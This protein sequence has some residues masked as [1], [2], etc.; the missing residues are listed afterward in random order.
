MRTHWLTRKRIDDQHL[1]ANAPQSGIKGYATDGI[2]GEKPF[3]GFQPA[4]A[5][6]LQFDDSLTANAPLEG[7]RAGLDL[8]PLIPGTDIYPEQLGA[9]GDYVP[10]GS[11]FSDFMAQAQH[12]TPGS[13]NAGLQHGSGMDSVYTYFEGDVFTNG[14]LHYVYEPRF[15]RTPIVTMW[16]QGFL[17][18]PN[19]FLAFQ[20]PQVWSNPNVVTNGIG[21]IVAGQMALQ[22]LETEEGQ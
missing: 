14:A 11:A 8:L 5:G 7:G 20:P 4:R 19:T 15:E 22:P 6:V 10:A 12:I 16:G 18:T 17:R 9:G 3:Q 13:G 21:G 2:T 1:V